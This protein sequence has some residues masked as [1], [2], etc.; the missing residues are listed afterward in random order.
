MYLLCLQYLKT[1]FTVERKYT[2]FNGMF[3]KRLSRRLACIGAYYV[4]MDRSRSL[5]NFMESWHCIY[6]ARIH[7]DAPRLGCWC[8]FL[9]FR[10]C[11]DEVVAGA[12][13]CFGFFLREIIINVV[14]IFY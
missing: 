7:V 1:H 4:C 8:L 11:V 13:V 3:E 5:N 2:N 6:L 10:Q 14:V 12:V 9:S